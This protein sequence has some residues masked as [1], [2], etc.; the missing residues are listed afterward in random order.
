[1]TCFNTTTVE[2][3]LQS[4]FRSVPNTVCSWCFAPFLATIDPVTLDIG[5][6][7]RPFFLE[8][9]IRRQHQ[10]LGNESATG[11]QQRA[12]VG[13]ASFWKVVLHVH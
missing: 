6:A 9:L 12:T 5:S 1:M 3:A 4:S 13:W 10:L 8:S 11:E 7:A 2:G